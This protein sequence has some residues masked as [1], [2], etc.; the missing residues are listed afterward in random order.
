[1]IRFLCR[2]GGKKGGAWVAFCSLMRGLRRG[3]GGG[4]RFSRRV[5]GD[6]GLGLPK[7]TPK[8]RCEPLDLT[9]AGW[10]G[11]FGRE[12]APRSRVSAIVER[13]RGTVATRRREGVETFRPSVFQKN[14]VGGGLGE[15]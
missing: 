4:C 8:G 10:G 13:V 11:P 3:A 12:T 9:G 6:D 5:A 14:R 2:L 7:F 1:M 15:R